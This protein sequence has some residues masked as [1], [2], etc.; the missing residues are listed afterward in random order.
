MQGLAMKLVELYK[1]EPRLWNTTYAYCVNADA[2][3]LAL[4]RTFAS[5]TA[6]HQ[7]HNAYEPV[8]KYIFWGLHDDVKLLAHY[9]FE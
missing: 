1:N 5:S 9:A 4:R 3:N 6:C 8:A 7:V 2:C